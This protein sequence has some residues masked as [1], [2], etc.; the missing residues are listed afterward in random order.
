[1]SASNTRHEGR[2]HKIFSV[3]KNPKLSHSVGFPAPILYLV[4]RLDVLIRPAELINVPV[5]V[6][7]HRLKSYFFQIFPKGH[8]GQLHS[9]EVPE[10]RVAELQPGLVPHG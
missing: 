10:S 9:A 2:L 5:P 7:N 6:H 4:Q 3:L 1:M 8:P